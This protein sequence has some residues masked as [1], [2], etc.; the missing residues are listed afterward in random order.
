MLF[1]AR[2][3][4]KIPYGDQHV[5]NWETFCRDFHVD[6][7]HTKLYCP[8][9]KIEESLV[10]EQM[11]HTGANPILR[12]LQELERGAH[13]RFPELVQSKLGFS[14]PGHVP[15]AQRRL[16]TESWA[17]FM[18]PCQVSPEQTQRVWEIAHSHGIYAW[19]NLSSLKKISLESWRFVAVSPPETVYRD[20]VT[21]HTAL[22]ELY[23]K[24]KRP[25]NSR[26]KTVSAYTVTYRASKPL[27]PILPMP[28]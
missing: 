6:A 12:R 17:E 18:L 8:D 26:G 5:L 9:G 3:S 16:F 14:S 27:E 25:A 19:L 21:I 24:L 22:S 28:R 15:D 7:L 20:Q 23:E 13:L 4:I 10:L 1:K 2:I 11:V